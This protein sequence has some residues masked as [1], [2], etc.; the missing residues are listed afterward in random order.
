MAHNNGP[1]VLE[2]VGVMIEVR[3][4]QRFLVFLYFLV[5]VILN[6]EEKYLNADFGH[7]TVG[8]VVFIVLAVDVDAGGG[9]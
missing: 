5:V 4:M 2:S 8:G 7:D 1:Y 6:L 9:F 3:S